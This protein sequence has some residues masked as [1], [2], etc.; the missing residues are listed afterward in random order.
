MHQEEKN[1]ITQNKHKI[2]SPQGGWRSSPPDCTA[3]CGL[4]AITITCF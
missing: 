1:T 4:P 3:C 2:K